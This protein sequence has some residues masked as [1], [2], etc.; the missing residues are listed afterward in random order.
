M[1]GFE[2][3]RLQA[4]NFKNEEELLEFDGISLQKLAGNAFEASCFA[5]CA[6]VSFIF[7]AKGAA[8]RTCTTYG[9]NEV[10]SDLDDIMMPAKR[11]R[12]EGNASALKT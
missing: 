12:T 5:A 11:Q 9:E 4:L 6:Y 10:D 3:F 2:S 7:I 8:Q 1:T